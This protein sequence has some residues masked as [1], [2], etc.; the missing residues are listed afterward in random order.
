MA[1]H[2]IDQYITLYIA[3]NDARLLTNTGR[4]AA[5]VAQSQNGARQWA[6]PTQYPSWSHILAAAA[7]ATRRVGLLVSYLYCGLTRRFSCNYAA[8]HIYNNYI[9]VAAIFTCSLVLCS[10]GL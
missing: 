6:G 7:T 10:S 8:A 5:A 1:I 4:L 2:P 3:W 9:Y